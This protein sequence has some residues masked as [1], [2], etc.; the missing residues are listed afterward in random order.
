MREKRRRQQLPERFLAW[1]WLPLRSQDRDSRSRM[2][3]SGSG[4]S[5]I[6][7]RSS[8]T[9]LWKTAK[10]REKRKL[11]PGSG[12]P[13]G[14]RGAQGPHP[15]VEA[16]LRGAQGD[17]AVVDGAQPSLFDTEYCCLHLS[18]DGARPSPPPR[19]L[20]HRHR[21]CQQRHGWYAYACACAVRRQG[22]R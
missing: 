13:A 18:L 9:L 15:L 8:L 16:G 5:Y 6:I 17:H 1:S 11:A 14:I 19:K 4:F 3:R 7:C 22:Y 21:D 20:R 10:T 12:R 2:C